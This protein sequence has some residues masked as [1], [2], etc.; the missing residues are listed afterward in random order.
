MYDYWVAQGEPKLRLNRRNHEYFT[1]HNSILTAN[2][3]EG[4]DSNRKILDQASSDPDTELLRELYT[5][6]KDKKDS[7]EL[8][9]KTGEIIPHLSQ[10]ARS[11]IC[12][13]GNERSQATK[14]GYKLGNLVGRDIRVEETVQ[15][16]MLSKKSNASHFFFEEINQGSTVPSPL[17][18][19]TEV[20][21]KTDTTF[22]SEEPEVVKDGAEDPGEAYNLGSNI[23]DIFD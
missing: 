1:L 19:E 18:P 21:E 17:T 3:Y 14:L 16:L 11:R 10:L 15:R 5:V 2:G 22:G 9:I 23:D 8:G 20:M 6:W 7:N 13:E 12:G 4:F